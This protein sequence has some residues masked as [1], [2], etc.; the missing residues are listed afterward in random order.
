MDDEDA[1]V[2]AGRLRQVATGQVATLRLEQRIAHASG[3]T[4][5]VEL[6]RHAA[7]GGRRERDG[8]LHEL[9]VHFEDLSRETRLTSAVA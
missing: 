7:P 2:F 1:A 6:Q 8:R 4:V 9:V 5:P 3:R